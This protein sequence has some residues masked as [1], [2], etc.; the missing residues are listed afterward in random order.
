MDIT[1]NSPTCVEIARF[2]I[3]ALG[4]RNSLELGKSRSTN[5]GRE[6]RANAGRNRAE[7]KVSCSRKRMKKAPGDIWPR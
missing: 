5:S 1:N 3:G 2:T 4:Q 7:Y 6:K